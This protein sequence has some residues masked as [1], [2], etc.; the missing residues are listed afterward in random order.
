M[1]FGSK[2]KQPQMGKLRKLFPAMDAIF[3]YASNTQVPEMCGL[4]DV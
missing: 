4:L 1:A 2:V 3:I